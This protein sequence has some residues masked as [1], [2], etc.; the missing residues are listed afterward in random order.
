M[1]SV[2][3]GSGAHSELVKPCGEHA[4]V[5]VC[6]PLGV[7]G[8]RLDGTFDAVSVFFEQGRT[9]RHTHRTQR[10]Y[11]MTREGWTDHPLVPA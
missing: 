8:I 2:F 1:S 7:T 6:V 11:G 3:G 4:G 10:S 5:C 9:A